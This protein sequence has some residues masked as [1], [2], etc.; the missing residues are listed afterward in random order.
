MASPKHGYPASMN[1]TGRK[2]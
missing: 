2:H 1:M